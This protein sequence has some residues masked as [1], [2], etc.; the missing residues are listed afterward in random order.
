MSPA[1]L[2]KA[3]QTQTSTL[4]E[5]GATYV[6]FDINVKETA[7]IGSYG[8]D[9]KATC[10]G[11]NG[12]ITVSLQ[13]TLKVQIVKELTPA[14]VVLSDIKVGNAVIGDQAQISFTLKN[15]GEIT[16]KNTYYHVDYGTSNI[17]PNYE[18]PNIKAG[19]IGPGQT[20]YVVLPVKVLSTATV[21]LKT[22]SVIID[23]KDSD[24]TKGSDTHQLFVDV[25]KNEKA[26]E[27]M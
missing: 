9:I 21:G 19:D 20:K 7:K 11:E 4:Y 25:K 23:Y 5:Y 24:G 22:L 17:I 13:P 1:K 10:P 2:T 26:P 15:E 3:D 8:I 18:T 16:A 14:Q 6:D 27:L 12:T